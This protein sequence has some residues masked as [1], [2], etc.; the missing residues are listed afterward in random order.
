L[1]LSDDPEGWNAGV[2]GRPK[3]EGVYVYI[4]LIH[5]VV[6]Q[7]LTQRWKTTILQF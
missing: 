7:K 2:R 3:R 6:Q 1:V 5:L 4:R